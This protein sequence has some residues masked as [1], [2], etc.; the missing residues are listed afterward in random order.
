MGHTVFAK[1]IIHLSQCTKFAYKITTAQAIFQYHMVA[2]AFN[3]LKVGT[4]IQ[5]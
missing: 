1:K 5:Q 4:L 2:N 3:A